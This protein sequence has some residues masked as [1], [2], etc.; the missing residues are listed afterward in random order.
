MA[1]LNLQVLALTLIP[2]LSGVAPGD[3]G[4]IQ[5]ASAILGVDKEVTA[6]FLVGRWEC[7]EGLFRWGVTDRQK[8]RVTPYRGKAS[9]S[10]NEDGT[11]R[12]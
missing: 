7:S 6:Q 12:T 4:I 10:L 5:D 3:V 8:A 2:F 11:L 1:L 9:M